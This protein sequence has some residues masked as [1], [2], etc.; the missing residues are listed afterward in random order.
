MSAELEIPSY[1]WQGR[2]R[3]GCGRQGNDGN[4]GKD[5]IELEY[6]QVKGNKERKNKMKECKQKKRTTLNSDC[7]NLTE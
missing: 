3:T 6:E 1:W 7:Q 5:C 4:Q 2:Q